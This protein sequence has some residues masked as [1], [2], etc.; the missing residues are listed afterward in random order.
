MLPE[1]EVGTASGLILTGHI[2]G[3]I[4]TLAVGRILELTGN[5]DLS[6]IILAVVSIITAGVTFMLPETGARANR[7]AV[8]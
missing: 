8:I 5:L 6:L 4:G 1:K 7:E 2:G 3:L